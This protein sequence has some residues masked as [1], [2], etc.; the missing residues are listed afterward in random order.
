LAG[1]ASPD[2]GGAAEAELAGAGVISSP[3]TD[4]LSTLSSKRSFPSRLKPDLDPTQ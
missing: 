4:A 2:R 1:A 3:G